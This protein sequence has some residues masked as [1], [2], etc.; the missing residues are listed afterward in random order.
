MK[1]T[2]GNLERLEWILP[3][4]DL[5]LFRDLSDGLPLVDGCSEFGRSYSQKSTSGSVVPMCVGN[6]PDNKATTSIVDMKV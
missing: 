3:K 6:Q 1:S 5:I 2:G 4:L